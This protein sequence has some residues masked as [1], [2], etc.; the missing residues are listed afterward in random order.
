MVALLVMAAPWLL[1]AIAAFCALG[2]LRAPDR[3]LA[4]APALAQAGID[5]ARYTGARRTDC[6]VAGLGAVAGALAALAPLPADLATPVGR[7]LVILAALGGVSFTARA[8]LNRY[9]AFP[10]YSADLQRVHAILRQKAL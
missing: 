1:L 4:V 8:V 2:Y 7:S 10:R 6:T 9:G 3:T 5:P